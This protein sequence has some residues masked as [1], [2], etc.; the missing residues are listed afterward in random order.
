MKLPK[1]KPTL[2]RYILLFGQAVFLP[3]MVVLLSLLFTNN[4]LRAEVLNS[5]R[6]AVKLIQKSLDSTFIEIEDILNHVG[7]NERLTQNQLQ[8]NPREALNSLS[9]VA[10]SHKCVADLILY[11]RGGENFYAIN[12]MFS[13]EH[14]HLR[15]FLSD[16]RDAGHTENDW[17]IM[18]D[19][20]TKTTYWSGVSANNSTYLC[21]VAPVFYPLQTNDAVASRSATVLLRQEYVQDLFRSSQS[22]SQESILLLSSDGVL[23]SKLTTEDT[24][25]LVPQ[26]CDYINNNESV[27]ESGY[28]ELPDTATLLLI[29]KSTETG[30][31]YVRFLPTDVA[32]RTMNAQQTFTVIVLAITLVLGLILIST[33]IRHSY[34]PLQSLAQWIRDRRPEDGNIHDELALFRSVLNDAFDRNEALSQVVD[35]SRQSLV[36]RLLADLLCGNYATEEDFRNACDQLDVHLDGKHFAVCS[37]LIEEDGTGADSVDFDRIF[38]CISSALPDR[39]QVQAKDLLFT[40]RF[41]LVLSTDLPDT[42]FYQTTLAFVK[43]RL[44][45]REKLMVSIGM[46]P[47]YDSY[48]KAARSYLDSVKA[49]DYRLVYGKNC[50]ITPDIYN[51]SSPEMVGSYPSYDLDLLDTALA[52]RNSEMAATILKRINAT[53]KLKNYN[54]DLAKYICYD[55][56]SILKKSSDFADISNSSSLPRPLNVTNLTNH[57]T[58]DDFFTALTELI[59]SRLGAAEQQNIPTAATAGNK[60]LEYADAHCLEYDFQ[61]KNMAE[62]FG[63]SPQYMRKLFKSHAGISI[64]EYVSNKRLERS[65][66]LL[67][68]T[69]MPLQDIVSEIGNS[70]ISGFV[71]FFKQKTGLTPGQ[72]RKTHQKI[73][74]K[75]F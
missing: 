47:F 35:T 29:S 54:L 6:S 12:G 25:A 55:I 41:I 42:K 1:L 53:V 15:A 70:D 22:T 74:N 56:F 73:E 26:I 50:L 68:Q 60:L 44:L 59:E 69:E 51:S 46:G 65:M 62:H 71:R 5:N 11:V 18:M 16:F 63:I 24:D 66:Y 61:I 67:A 38:S 14:L 72:Y 40:R 3:V 36:E 37:M 75:V 31:I 48:A 52:S 4:A 7:A 10:S 32:Y 49:L 19:N 17:L 20:A 64:S 39:Y 45:E 33:G 23:L 43:Q 27:I 21:V 13:K 8:N 58:I 9:D 28:A 2:L 30:M 57:N 34:V